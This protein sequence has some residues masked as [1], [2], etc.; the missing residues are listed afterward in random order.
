MDAARCK[1]FYPKHFHLVVLQRL[2]FCERSCKMTNELTGQLIETS[3]MTCPDEHYACSLLQF[4]YYWTRT[5]CTVLQHYAL[6]ANWNPG[7][8]L[9]D[10]VQHTI[11]S[12][13]LLQVMHGAC[14]NNY[15]NF[16]MYTTPVTT[17]QVPQ[18]VQGGSER[19]CNIYLY[20]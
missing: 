18:N 15:T 20:M 10:P 11:S 14:F 6:R 8:Q 3:K 7:K 1:R 12:L 9:H 2:F 5:L 17:S 4:N 13:R 16:K 19:I